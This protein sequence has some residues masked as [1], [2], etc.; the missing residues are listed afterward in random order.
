MKKYFTYILV[1]LMASALFYS[2]AHAQR[3]KKKAKKTTTKKKTTSKKS[4]SKNNTVQLKASTSN[5]P[6]DQLEVKPIVET[7]KQDTLP[8][9]VVTIFSAF[10]PQL[11]NIAKIDFVNASERNDTGSIR[12]EY[13]VP[14]QNLSFQYRPIALVPRTF[15]LDSLTVLNRNTFL[16]FGYGNYFHHYE[17]LGHYFIDQYNN[18]HSFNI[19]NEG[20]SGD[21]HLQSTKELKLEYIGDYAFKDKGHLL[22]KL[23]Y[24]QTGRYRYG[25]V[26]DSSVLPL[27]NFKQN[28]FLSGVSLGWLTEKNKVEK[29]KYAPT[30]VFE[31]FEG[32]EGATNNFIQLNSPLSVDLNKETKFNFDLSYAMNQFSPRNKSSQTNNFV[33]IDPSLKFNKYGSSFKIGVSPVLLNSELHLYPDVAFKKTLKDTNIILSAGW[34]AFVQNNSYAYI[35]DQNPWIAVPSNIEMTTQEKKFVEI[36]IS[37]G[38]RLQYGFALSLNDYTN[39][40]L[41]NKLTNTNLLNNGLYYNSIFEKKAS[42]IQ[43]DAH[44]RYQFSD[45]LLLTNNLQYIQFNS[46]EIN[47]K[48]WGILPL[49]LNSKIS[50]M[51]SQKLQIDGSMQFWSGAAMY[52]NATMP[53]DLDNAL[54]LNTS[55]KYK[56]SQQFSGWIKG[57]NLLDQRYQRWSNYP[58]LGVQLIAGVVYSFK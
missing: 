34:H 25:M 48:P 46:I 52:N 28:S 29:L 47:A 32:I 33:R 38:K 31:R 26:P 53:Y 15:K 37:N 43:F 11:K 24:K 54:V 5:L 36:Q 6:K 4:K 50:W 40:L 7:V 13:Q 22:S 51:P 3:N 20:I 57:E 21:H 16:K 58:S 49:S 27:A 42:T 2:P 41:F 35:A 39:M 14:S 10:K 19:N 8:E 1:L 12:I 9:K 23:Y 45:H 56:F 55:L 17:E 44:L 30:L 18:T